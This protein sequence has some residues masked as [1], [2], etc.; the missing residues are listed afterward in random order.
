MYYLVNTNN[1]Q[2]KIIALIV[3][4]VIV[5]G[6]AYAYTSY[7]SSRGAMMKDESAAV[8]N[9]DSAM[10]HD[11]G[12]MMHDDTMAA[13]SSNDSMMHDEMHD[14]AGAEMMAH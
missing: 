1:M 7:N 4:L 9:S 3:G 12:A 2:T 8:E 5:S 11:E 6:G 10:A 14:K 13:T